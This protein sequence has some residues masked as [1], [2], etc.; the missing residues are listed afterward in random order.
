[1]E[2]ENNNEKERIVKIEIVIDPADPGFK[3]LNDNELL[4]LKV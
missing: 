1:M 3:I 2:N 4:L